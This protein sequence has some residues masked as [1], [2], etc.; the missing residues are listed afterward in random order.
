M[1]LNEYMVTVLV[2]KRS[3]TPLCCMP[4]VCWFRSN[5]MKFNR[6]TLTVAADMLMV[7]LSEKHGQILDIV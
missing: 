5:L 3:G 2:V 7:K 1:V 6:V 4:S